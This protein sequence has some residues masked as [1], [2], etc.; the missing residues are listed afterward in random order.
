MSVEIAHSIITEF[1]SA[2]IN[3]I[4][5]Q[6]FSKASYFH[7]EKYPTESTNVG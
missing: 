2:A 3:A 5:K 4:N 6:I 1:F 7:L